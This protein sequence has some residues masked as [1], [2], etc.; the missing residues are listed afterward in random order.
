M[1]PARTLR[2]NMAAT[3]TAGCLS[4]GHSCS[5]KDALEMADEIITAAGPD[6]VEE[7]DYPKWMAEFHREMR[8]LDN[9]YK[10]RIATITAEKATLQAWKDSSMKEWGDLDVQAVGKALALQLGK[11]ILPAILPEILALQT[12]IEALE[13]EA[14]NQMCRLK[15]AQDRLKGL[16]DA[17]RFVLEDCVDM[18]ETEW[19]IRLERALSPTQGTTEGGAE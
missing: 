3:I 13:H 19:G 12:R 15:E 18:V 9:G 8:H 17:A 7:V 10:A 6:S 11:P 16:E 14:E 2:L 4:G 5:P 1:N